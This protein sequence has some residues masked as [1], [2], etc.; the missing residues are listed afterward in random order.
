MSGG[1]FG[2]KEREIES[3]EYMQTVPK[4]R[5]LLVCRPVAIQ[6]RRQ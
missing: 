3:N 6:Q 1:A 2:I 4:G 5:E